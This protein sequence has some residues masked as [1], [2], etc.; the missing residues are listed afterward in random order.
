MG[1]DGKPRKMTGFLA[2]LSE[3]QRAAIL[4]NTIDYPIGAGDPEEAMRMIAQMERD[5]E[6]KT[7]P[8]GQPD[9]DPAPRP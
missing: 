8:N 7:E 5:A 9:N 2:T 1:K 3:T 4:A 6:G